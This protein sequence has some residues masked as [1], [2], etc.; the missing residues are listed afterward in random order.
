MKKNKT[1]FDIQVE[2]NHNFAIGSVNDSVR[3]G[4]IVSNCELDIWSQMR[5]CGYIGVDRALDWKRKWEEKMEK[6]QL[7][8]TILEMSYE[9]AGIKLPDIHHYKMEIK[10]KGEEKECY[11]FV[12]GKARKVYVSMTQDLTSFSNVVVLF[13]RLRQC[14]VAPYLMTK[15]S[16][17]IKGGSLG[18]ADANKNK[19]EVKLMKELY[20]GS[21]GTWLHDK[22]GT[23]GMK[24]SK[25]QAIIK[26]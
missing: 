7:H 14:C 23:A 20:K 4:P 17:R 3:Y 22:E 2:D 1:V 11:D 24:S 5:F 25:I 13:L 26:R 10:L 12:M 15:E 8:T 21:L 9:D 16:K 19:Q 6:Q 18:R